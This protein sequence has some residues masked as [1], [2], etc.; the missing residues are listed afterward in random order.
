[1][2]PSVANQV[3]GSTDSNTQWEWPV[4]RLAQP[5]PLRSARRAVPRTGD[6]TT[7]V[8][9]SPGAGVPPALS[10]APVGHTPRDRSKAELP[11]NERESDRR[12][13]RGGMRPDR[14]SR[15]RGPH[16]RVH[17]LAAGSC[18]AARSCLGAGVQPT[19][20]QCTP[21]ECASGEAGGFLEDRAH[22]EKRSHHLAHAT[23]TTRLR[24]AHDGSMRFREWVFSLFFFSAVGTERQA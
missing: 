18:G 3:S 10:R 1:V 6:S 15:C 23:R 9:D 4:W 13:G 5:R 2:Q 14:T 12:T 19:D 20:A 21:V 11:D 8:R 24:M 17:G 7:T 22:R 16:W